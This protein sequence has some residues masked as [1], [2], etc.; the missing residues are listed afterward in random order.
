MENKVGYAYISLDEYKE[1]IG[2]IKTLEFCYDELR[3]KNKRT[4][5][6]YEN[7]EK[8]IFEKIYNNNSYQI[9]NY[10]GIGEYYHNKLVKEFQEYGYTSLDKIN[11]LIQKLVER[12]KNEEGNEKENEQ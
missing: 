5:K 4:I 1:L 10:D 11:E 12:Y 8:T 6:E 3:E 9:E 7:I 2:R